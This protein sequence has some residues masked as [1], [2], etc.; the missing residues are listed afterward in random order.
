MYLNHFTAGL[1][2][3][4]GKVKQNTFFY[5]GLY[6]LVLPSTCFDVMNREWFSLSP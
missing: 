3:I 6:F 5:T 1:E 2:V 4:P